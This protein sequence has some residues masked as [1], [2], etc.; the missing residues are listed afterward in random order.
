M[1]MFARPLRVLVRMPARNYLML[2]LRR[3]GGG[4]H[5]LRRNWCIKVVRRNFLLPV[6]W[7]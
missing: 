1:R 7:G 6:S 2:R 5:G 3:F 4:S